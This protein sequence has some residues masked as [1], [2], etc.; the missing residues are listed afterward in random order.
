MNVCV[1]SDVFG[2]TRKVPPL[3]EANYAKRL[4]SK[5]Y[6]VVVNDTAIAWPATCKFLE[7]T[8]GLAPTS[9]RWW[10]LTK[11]KNQ[12]DNRASPGYVEW[13][14]KRDAQE[15]PAYDKGLAIEYRPLNLVSE[16]DSSRRLFNS[17]SLN[18]L[19]VGFPQLISSS[20]YLTERGNF[21]T[22]SLAKLAPIET[23][24]SDNEKTDTMKG[25]EG[26]HCPL[27]GKG[28]L[29]CC[30]KAACVLKLG[31]GVKKSEDT[32]CTSS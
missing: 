12:A 15:G 27:E 6:S 29:G 19:S 2:G 32:E 16:L 17:P 23:R 20:N 5:E 4:L 1:F 31:I 24:T 30:G 3:R 9:F 18:S 21:A 10:W 14:R 8:S 22:R 25:H 11:I 13:L 7:G 28:A 26:V